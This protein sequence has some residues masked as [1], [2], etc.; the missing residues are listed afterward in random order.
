MRQGVM[1]IIGL[2]GDGLIT[3]PFA[4]EIMRSLDNVLRTHGLSVLVTDI[5]TR[6]QIY[7]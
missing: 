7:R 4:T 1:P 2:I 6:G 3:Q 5:G